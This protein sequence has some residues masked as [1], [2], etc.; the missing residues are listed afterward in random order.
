M[1]RSVIP[2]NFEAIFRFS[3][4]WL[5]VFFSKIKN[6]NSTLGSGTNVRHRAEFHQNRSNDCWERWRF[7][8]FQNSG[9]PPCWIL[10]FNFLT[11]MPLRHILHH[12]ARFRERRQRFVNVCASNRIVFVCSATELRWTW[13]KWPLLTRWRMPEVA[14]AYVLGCDVYLLHHHRCCTTHS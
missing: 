6:F 10:E 5:R 9:C 13:H 1:R 4:L 12:C 11:A 3:N 8:S 2:E 14:T 7:N